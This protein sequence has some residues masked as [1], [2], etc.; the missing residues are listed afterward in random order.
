M[1]WEDVV[2]KKVG[3]RAV[4]DK[5][6]GLVFEIIEYTLLSVYTLWDPSMMRN[7]ILSI[8]ETS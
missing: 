6:D 5:Y 3:L 1:F 7:L 2:H 8:Q 4:V